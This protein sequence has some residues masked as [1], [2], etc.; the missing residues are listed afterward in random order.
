MDNPTKNISVFPSTRSLLLVF[1]QID[2][3]KR[4]EKRKFRRLLNS[5][6]AD[7]DDEQA[8]Q[9]AAPQERAP[10]QIGQP[11]AKQ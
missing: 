5:I 3:Y 10:L 8:A 7:T 6:V 1:A 9:G 4:L 11:E 2:A